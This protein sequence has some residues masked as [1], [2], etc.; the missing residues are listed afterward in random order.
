MREASAERFFLDVIPIIPNKYRPATLGDD[1]RYTLHPLNS[2]FL[3]IV[4][5][6]RSS[7]FFFLINLV[8]QQRVD[9]S[10]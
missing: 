8:E 9:L 10:K 3:G 2:H 5:V 4:Q 6:S 7:S 1:G